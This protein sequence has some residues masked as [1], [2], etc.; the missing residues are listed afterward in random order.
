VEALRNVGT[1]EGTLLITGSVTDLSPLECLG[2][3]TGDLAVYETEALED[4]SGLERLAS[5][6]GTLYVGSRCDEGPGECVGNAALRELSGLRNLV[7]AKDIVIAAKCFGE[8]LDEDCARNAALTKVS[9]EGLREIETLT[10]HE[11][12]VLTEV[13]LAALVGASELHVESAPAL[14]LLRFPSITSLE[15]LAVSAAPMLKEL[16]FAQLSEVGLLALNRTGLVDLRAFE[17][18]SEVGALY[19]YGNP[20]LASLEGVGRLER[21]RV[22]IEANGA[23]ALWPDRARRC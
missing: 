6:G 1:I 7:R 5:L 15:T 17:A 14:T 18:L 4:L 22:T 23:F 19:V 3:V 12:L 21:G 2:E 11:N 10:L 9:F 13:H 16:A 20:E 8:G